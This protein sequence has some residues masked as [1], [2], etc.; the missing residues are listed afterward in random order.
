MDGG[1]GALLTLALVEITPASHDVDTA[2]GTARVHVHAPASARALLLLGH[3]AGG[4]LHSADLEAARDAALAGQ[5]AVGLVEQPWRVAGR[6]TAAPAA[7]LDAAWRD[8]AAA[9][10][11]DR[12]LLVGGRSSGA[13]VACRTADALG[14][15]AVLVLAFPLVSPRG[16]SRLAELLAPGVPR[17]V[18]QGSRDSFGVPDPS[19]GVAVHVVCGADHSFRVRKADGRT[20]ADVRAE[21]CGVVTAWL[22]QALT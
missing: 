15:V 11:D 19:P 7:Q 13:R 2:A 6:R 10:R 17:Q 12:P 16:A 8:V 22:A 18:V 14:A 5:I 21:V 20:A 3:G 9:L 1:H 4:A